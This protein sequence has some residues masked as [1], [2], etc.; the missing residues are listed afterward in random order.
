VFEE[1]QASLRP[2]NEQCARSALFRCRY[3]GISI[4]EHSRNFILFVITFSCNHQTQC[5]SNDRP[6]A[7]LIFL[8][9]AFHKA[10]VNSSNTMDKDG[11]KKLKFFSI[12]LKISILSNNNIDYGVFHRFFY[13][14]KYS[15]DSSRVTASRAHVRAIT[16]QTT[17]L[18]RGIWNNFGIIEPSCVATC[19]C[20]SR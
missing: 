14:F 19:V 10:V 15:R 16:S 8:F 4:A 20:A 5:R 6:Y 18:M 17:R 7:L 1:K 11:C 9:C 13:L 2:H 12:K 3:R